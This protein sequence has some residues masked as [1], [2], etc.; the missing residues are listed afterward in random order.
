[1]RKETLK[2][3]AAMLFLLAAFGFAGGCDR[4]DA[5]VTPP[6]VGWG[7]AYQQAATEYYAGYEPGLCGAYVVEWDS[8]R[9][10][11]RDPSYAGFATQ[12]A[13]H[14]PECDIAIGP[15]KGEGVYYRCIIYAHEYGH[16][17][18]LGHSSNVHDVM[19]YAP[20]A[21]YTF[22]KPCAELVKRVQ[23][24]EEG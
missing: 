20:S 10:A 19:Y 8:P 18:G 24:G 22:D 9:P 7:A 14:M 2:T 11:E 21:M 12:P 5:A 3:I 13:Q 23:S 4:A 6:S 15:T 1:M 16:T 17:L